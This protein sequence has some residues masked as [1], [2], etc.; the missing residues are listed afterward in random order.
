MERGRMDLGSTMCG[1]CDVPNLEDEPALGFV[2]RKAIA[3]QS[4]GSSDPSEEP[5][6]YGT[7]N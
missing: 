2:P 5:S 7:Q 1:V 3:F 6:I 4:S